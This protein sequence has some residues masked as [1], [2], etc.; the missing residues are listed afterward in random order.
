[1]ATYLRALVAEY[2]IS[3]TELCR[4]PF[5]RDLEGEQ[6]K[7]VVRKRIYLLSTRYLS[8]VSCFN[9]KLKRAFKNRDPIW[10]G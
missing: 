2:N 10:D 6:C 1:M 7:L 4:A 9:V 5:P 3:L 8:T